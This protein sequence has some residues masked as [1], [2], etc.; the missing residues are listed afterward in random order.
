MIVAESYPNKTQAAGVSCGDVSSGLGINLSTP[1]IKV[2]IMSKVLVSQ[3]RVNKRI[4]VDAIYPALWPEDAAMVSFTAYNKRFDA[5]LRITSGR[6][7]LLPWP[8]SQPSPIFQQR[9]ICDVVLLAFRK[10]DIQ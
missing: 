6:A 5:R 4:H 9:H 1:L 2:L 3:D 10:G 8:G 7:V